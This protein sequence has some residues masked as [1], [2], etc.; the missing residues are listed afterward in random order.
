MIS[1]KSPRY[2]EA[3]VSYDPNSAG[4][5]YQTV[6]AKGETISARIENTI[7]GWRQSIIDTFTKGI[8]SF[9]QITLYVFH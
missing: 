1:V 5:P 8:V 7:T 4:A 3:P 6:N 2:E 9:L